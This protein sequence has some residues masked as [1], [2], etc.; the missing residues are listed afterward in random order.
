V[1]LALENHCPLVLVAQLRHTKADLLRRIGRF[2]EA[3]EEVNAIGSTLM[4]PGLRSQFLHTKAVLLDECGEP[5]ALEH[6]LESYQQDCEWRCKTSPQSGGE[7]EPKGAG[8]PDRRGGP[9]ASEGW[10]VEHREGCIAWSCT[11][12]YAA[13]SLLRG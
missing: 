12:K 7:K 3:V 9:R 5:Q 10:D 1:R 11:H 4:P 8:K 2:R 13:V 6:L